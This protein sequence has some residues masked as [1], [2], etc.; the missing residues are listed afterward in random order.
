MDFFIFVLDSGKFIFLNGCLY[1]CSYV[2]HDLHTD[3]Q[4]EVHFAYVGSLDGF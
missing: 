3:M 2:M 4:V 1:A